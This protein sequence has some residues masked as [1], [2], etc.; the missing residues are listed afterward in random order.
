M[1]TIYE[2]KKPVKCERWDSNIGIHNTNIHPNTGHEGKRLVKCE[3]CEKLDSNFGIHIIASLKC[4]LK[5]V[6]KSYLSQQFQYINAIIL[7][8]ISI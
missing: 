2:G 5:F 4:P 7:P 3:N 8:K 6:K 1:N